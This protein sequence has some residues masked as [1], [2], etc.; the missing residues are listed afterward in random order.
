MVPA[1]TI[2]LYQRAHGYRDHISLYQRAHGFRDHN[3][4]PK[5]T[6]AMSRSRQ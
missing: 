4:I 5:F 2:S 3:K 1:T 6:S